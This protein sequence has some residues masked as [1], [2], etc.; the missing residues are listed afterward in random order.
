M[1][2]RLSR[3]NIEQ[4]NIVD[5]SQSV[6]HFRGIQGRVTHAEG[7]VPVRYFM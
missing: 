3:T 2:R 5:I 1:L 6:A 4:M 7:F